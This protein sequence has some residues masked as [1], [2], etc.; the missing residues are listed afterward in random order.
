[1][2]TWA[3][4]DPIDVRISDPGEVAASL[5]HLLGFRPRE[6]VV[7]ISLR[8]PTGGRV[9]LTL[10]ADIPEAAHA[11]AVAR[12]L[13]SSVCTDGPRR[14]LM[15]VV[16]EAAD[17]VA[18]GQPVLPHQSL[19]WE[20]TKALT[21]LTVPVPDVL[22]IRGGRWWSYDCPRDCCAPSAGTALPGGVTQLEV[23]AV[24]TGTV[25]EGDR[26]DLEARLRRPPGFDR[27]AMAAASVRAAERLSAAIVADGW[28]AAAEASWATLGA[29]VARCR[30][31]SARPF[32][33]DEIARILW[34]LRDRHVRDR[35]LGFALG[36]DAAAAEVLWTECARRGLA[37]LDAAPATLLAVSA[38]LRGDGAMANVALA[39]A[40]DADP[41]YRL[42]Q[43]L[44][45]GLA[46]CLAP[47]ELR[48]MISGTLDDLGVPSDLGDA[49]RVG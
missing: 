28:D 26:A 10:R 11:A 23:A 46:K 33:D 21:A 42:A 25:V 1:M 17:D 16:S 38:W 39:H 36:S 45:Q 37:P 14:V 35:A 2:G 3:D 30:P 22:L 40:L 29:A 15:A 24:A 6:S 19:V 27:A 5:P 13:A 32:S 18:G 12:E 8:G 47:A 34:A 9:G 41:A 20:L 31:G 44:A 4:T 48:L 49:D 7:L 43:L